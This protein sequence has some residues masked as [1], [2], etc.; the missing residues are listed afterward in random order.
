M[1]TSFQGAMQYLSGLMGP[2]GMKGFGIHDNSLGDDINN[3][4]H[5][6]RHETEENGINEIVTP[7]GDQFGE[8]SDKWHY[9]EIV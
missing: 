1:Q 9:N 4:S 5:Q 7:R 6:R 3:R 8:T 2:R